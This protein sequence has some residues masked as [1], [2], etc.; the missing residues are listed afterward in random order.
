[1]N[2]RIG[3]ISF[4]AGALASFLAGRLTSGLAAGYYFVGMLVWDVVA[5]LAGTRVADERLVILTLTAL[6]HG[7]FFAIIV[8]IARLLFPRVRE[9]ELGGNLLLVGAV[10]YG[11]LLAV[12]F[13]VRE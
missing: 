2:I 13:P 3:L 8:M 11:I 9:E 10:V 12:A 4:G 5:R 7:L 6:V 1:M